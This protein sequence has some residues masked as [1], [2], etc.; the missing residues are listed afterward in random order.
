MG[1]APSARPSRQKILV[2][3]DD[4][5][6]REVIAAMLRSAGYDVKLAKDGADAVAK[7]R[8]SHFDLVFL[9]VWM[10]GLS[11]L[12]A[13]AQIRE[14]ASHPKVI[15]M[16]SDGTPE[17]VLRAVRE[18]A[19]EFV[20]KPFPP[21]HAIELAQRA[22][23]DKTALQI[24]VISA[25]P[26]WVELSI[27]CTREAAER[28]QGF[29][30]HLEASLSEDIR[31]T[32]GQAFREL[33]LNAV[34]WGGKLDPNRRVR[35]AQLRSSRMILYRI[36]DPGPG[37]R[38]E[39]LEHAAVGHPEDP[40]AHVEVRDKLGLRPGGFGIMMIQALADELLYNEARNEV[41]F[42]KYLPD[43]Q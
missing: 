6:T 24:E 14:T 41:V 28:V 4:A 10:P 1:I 9:D 12:D 2:A 22:L 20:S 32:V 26:H 21:K 31:A 5:T 40:V 29:I 18:Q 16:T 27:P 7:A 17:N 30:M 3:D 37:F 38:M 13:L 33:L 42:I 35:I 25:K 36:A 19:Y 15:I 8:G 39:D 11:G 43:S 34:E 23:E